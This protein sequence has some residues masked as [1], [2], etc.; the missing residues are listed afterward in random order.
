MPHQTFVD[1]AKINI[2]A[3]NGG[4]GAV[5]FRREKYIPKGG[6]DGGDGGKG[7][8]V[9]LRAS[10][11]KSTLLD[12][13]KKRHFKAKNGEPGKG[14]QMYGAQGS[15]I[16]I[17]VPLGTIAVDE[18]TQAVL[19]EVLTDGQTLLLQAGGK[20]GLG[21][22]HFKSSTNRA[23]RK[24]TYGHKTEDVWILLELKLLSEV[25]IVGLP[26]AGKSTLLGQISRAKPKAADYPFTSLYPT[27]GV[28]SEGTKKWIVADLPGLIEGASLG[29]GLGIAFLRHIQRTKVLLFLLSA[30]EETPDQPFKDFKILQNEIF[31][32]DQTMKEKPFIVAINKVDL[33]SPKTQEKMIKKF[34]T[35]KLKPLFISAKKGEGT[36]ELVHEISKHI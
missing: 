27:L 34:G 24:F 29:K 36:Q 3:G 12:F 17:D 25:G 23:P 22:I 14:Q 20:G 8:S 6:P 28:V 2:K 5:S 1:Q 10:V 33:I 15:D 19:G 11:H 32:F 13:Q 35:K 7:G 18:A 21:N 26:N 4:N 9:Y 31:T 30:N 16:Y